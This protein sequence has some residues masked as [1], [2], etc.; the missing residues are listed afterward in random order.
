MM[1]IF[2]VV[3]LVLAGV[4]GWLGWQYFGAPG[5]LFGGNRDAR[6]GVS[7]VVA[8]E[9]KRKL[10]LI[11]R[12]GVEHLVMT[13]G[14][15]DVVIEQGIQAPAQPH[16]RAASNPTPQNY[17]PRAVPQPIPHAPH[18]EAGQEPAPGFGR[19]RQRSVSG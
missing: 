5:T 3:L 13:G 16:F 15:I 2:L 6:I 10:L 18:G 4:G 11:Y 9:G 8:V 7:E 12:D 19:L 14:P 17:E 1:T